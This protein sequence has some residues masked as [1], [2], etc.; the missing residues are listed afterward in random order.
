MKTSSPGTR[1][2]A[3][4]LAVA[5]AL[6]TL[7]GCGSSNLIWVTGRITKGGAPFA[8]PQDRK[9]GVTLIAIEAKGEGGKS[10]NGGEPFPSQVNPEDG[11]FVVPGPDGNGIPP[12][13][14]RV[15]LTLKPTATAVS[16][17]QAK[18]G[19]RKTINSDTDFFTKRYDPGNSPVVRNLETSCELAI[20]LDN[21][22]DEKAGG[23]R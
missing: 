4:G 15:A 6:T 18:A 11:T 10:I 7:P 9:L 21:P 13:R 1:A 2:V 12:G 20:D 17:A 19:K 22:A 3:L 8:C 23:L 14:Y 5:A 16:E